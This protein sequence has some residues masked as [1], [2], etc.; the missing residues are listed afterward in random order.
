MTAPSSSVCSATGRPGACRSP[1]RCRMRQGGSPRPSSSAV[2]SSPAA[3]ARSFWATT[4]STAMGLPRS[5]PGHPPAPAAPR[6]SPI[7]SGIRSATA[8]SSSTTTAGPSPSS[9]SPNRRAPTGRSRASISTTSALPTSPLQIQPSWR[10][11]LEITDVNRAY[12]E[13]GALGV[14]TLGRGYAWLDTG[15]VRV[16]APGRRIRASPRAP[17]RPED[18]LPRGDRLAHGLHRQGAAARAG[19]PPREERLRRLSPAGRGGRG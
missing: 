16:P 19:G 12:L 7:G 9:R 3:P 6:S 2:S 18:L 1:T 15:H 13:L 8:S 17:A 4:S 14:A 5:W 10:G 11:E